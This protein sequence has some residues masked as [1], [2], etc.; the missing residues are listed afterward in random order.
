[1]N[2]SMQQRDL[3]Q[4]L[5]DF[6]VDDPA[7][8][9][10]FSDRLAGEN[11]WSMT[12]SLRVVEEYKRFVLLAM[13][14]DHI[15]CPSE[16]VDQAWHL[17]L[18]YTKSYWCDLCENT[19]G[20]PLHHGPTTG[21]PAEAIKFRELYERTK[22]TYRHYFQQEPPPDIW[23]DAE[24]RFGEDLNV[25]RVNTQHYWLVPKPR[26]LVRYML[27]SRAQEVVVLGLAPLLFAA[28]NPL[29][30][31]GPDFLLLF[32]IVY[33]FSTV[34][35]LVLRRTLRSEWGERVDLSGDDV[36]D[37]Y[38]VAYLAGGE[39]RV[40]QAATAT[41]VRTAVLRLEKG[42]PS[43]R[44]AENMALPEHAHEVEAAVYAAV[45]ATGGK[46]EGH[47]FKKFAA[48]AFAKLKRSLVK[49]GLVET[50][51]SF[52]MSRLWPLAVLCPVLILGVIKLG[53]G[54]SRERPVGFLIVGLAV[55]VATMGWFAISQP[56]CTI[57]GQ[58]LLRELQRAHGE[59]KQ[60]ME[61]HEGHGLNSDL[62]FNVALLGVAG[63]LSPSDPISQL[64]A[65][66]EWTGGDSGSSAGCAASGCGAGC[67]GGGCG[68]GGCG[69]CGGCGG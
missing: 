47:R 41:L 57:A 34:A 36:K 67:G 23:P 1:M 4:K 3:Y 8:Q 21:G 42:I 46:L 31:R 63:A 45:K 18:T 44:L 54:L 33:M 55:V 38:E 16:Q 28:V 49:K 66:P 64:F 69:G 61:I 15:V 2:L 60:V 56:R 22:A 58:R 35:A 7:S 62:A 25:R 59:G 39:A 9:L 5:L 37:P 10:P 26:S 53:V 43:T 52:M 20:R 48:V 19:L 11:G 12:Y 13:L 14:A 50:G 29:D 6:P 32:G 40:A 30:L 17:H 27:S 68:G 51:S 65:G 24:T